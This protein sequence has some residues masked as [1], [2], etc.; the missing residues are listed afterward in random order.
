MTRLPK[1]LKRKTAVDS[2]IGVTEI[3]HRKHSDYFFIEVIK[4]EQCNKIQY[5]FKKKFFLVILSNEYNDKTVITFIENAII[6]LRDV[7]IVLRLIV[8]H[9]LIAK[10][11]KS[12]VFY[13]YRKLFVQV[14]L[15]SKINIKFF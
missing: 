7:S 3:L 15:I 4:C 9:S 6:E 11:L 8:L 12:N 1:V 10:G 5:I 13:H 14:F 2:L